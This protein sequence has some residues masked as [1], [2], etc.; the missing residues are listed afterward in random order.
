MDK[1]QIMICACHSVEHQIVFSYDAEDNQAYVTIHLNKFSL[2]KR[3]KQGVKY[4]FGHTS[5]FGDFD[6]IILN[7]T[8]A[9]ALIDLGNK[10]TK[11]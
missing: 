11:K 8:H 1:P 3:I 10:L 7:D 5:I 9:D 4:I 2:W 6:E